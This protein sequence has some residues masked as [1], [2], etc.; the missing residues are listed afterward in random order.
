[1]RLW[2]GCISGQSVYYRVMKLDPKSFKVVM[3]C[4]S[5]EVTA[6]GKV[7]VRS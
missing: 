3:N 7:L 5:N 4:T 1:M 2:L 6:R